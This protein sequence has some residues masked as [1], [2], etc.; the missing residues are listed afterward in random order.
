MYILATLSGSQCQFFL[1]TILESMVYELITSEIVQCLIPAHE[2]YF[3][4]FYTL[5]TVS[6]ERNY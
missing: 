4:K 5:F 1:E 6:S 3:I 2:I